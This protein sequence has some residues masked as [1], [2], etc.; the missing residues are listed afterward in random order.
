MTGVL[1]FLGS[2]LW[3]ILPGVF[4]N[5]TPVLVKKHF[6]FLATPVDGGREWHGKPFL[7][8]H[9]T[10]RGFIFGTAAGVAVGALQHW[11]YFEVPF[12]KEVSLVDFSEISG[13]F[14][15]FLMGFGALFG[16]SVKSFFKRRVD[17]QPG[18]PFFPWDQLDAYFGSIVF[19]SLFYVLPWEM[20]LMGVFIIPILH[21]GFNLAGYYLGIKSNKF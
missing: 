1:L 18:K 7:G 11:L 20:L 19:I 12:F 4:A 15:G 2:F 16:D 14:F 9:K 3:T 21:V 17:I 10:W 5:M 13:W 8:S 6:V